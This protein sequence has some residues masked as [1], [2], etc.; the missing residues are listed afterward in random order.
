[1]QPV[2]GANVADCRLQMS[3]YYKKG[4]IVVSTII[5]MSQKLLLL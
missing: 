5:P 2:P 3:R 4:E 1:V